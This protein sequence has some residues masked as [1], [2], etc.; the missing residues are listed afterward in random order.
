[1]PAAAGISRVASGDPNRV[2]P[3]GL[4]RGL[5]LGAVVARVGGRPGHRLGAGVPG[6]G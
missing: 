4:A 5:G 3:M 1:M 2:T 6:T